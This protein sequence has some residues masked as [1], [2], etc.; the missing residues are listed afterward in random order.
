MLNE[1]HSKLPRG[2][3]GTFLAGEC[4]PDGSVTVHKSPNDGHTSDLKI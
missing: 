2:P 1:L 3:D 4:G